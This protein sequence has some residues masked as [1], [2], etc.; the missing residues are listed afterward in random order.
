MTIR[1][2]PLRQFAQ[3]DQKIVIITIPMKQEQEKPNK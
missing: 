3:I 1:A 2:N